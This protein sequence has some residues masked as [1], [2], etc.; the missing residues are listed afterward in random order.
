MFT[1]SNKCTALVQDV[2]SGRG[3]AY[4]VAEGHTGKPLYFPLNFVEN[5]KLF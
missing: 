4:V 2:D 3:Y 1:G 5:L